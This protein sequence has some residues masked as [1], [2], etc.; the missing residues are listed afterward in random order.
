MHIELET[1]PN[2]VTNLRVE[3]PPDRVSLERQSIVKDFQGAARLPGYRVG[4]APKTL[5]ETRYKKEILD[6]LQRKLVSTATREAIAEKKLRVLS[7]GNVNQV[8]LG[9]DDTLRF[10][11]RVITAPEFELPPY[12]GLAVKVPPAEVA[13]ADVDRALDNL[14]QRLADFTD[15]EGRGLQMDD[16]SVIDFAAR[17]DGQ[18]VSEAIPDA[19]KELAG[20]EKFW[21]KLGP[22]TLLPGFSEALLGANAGDTR[23]FSLTVPADF[24]IESLQGKTL[25]YTVKVLELKQQALPELDDAFAEKVLPGK[26]LAQL[27]DLAREQLG[28][29]RAA[30]I[31]D[32]KRRQILHLLTAG[33]QF[34][35]PNEFVRGETQRIMGDIVKQNQER[36]VSDDEIRTN[37]KDIVTNADQAARERLKGAFIL[38]RIA[39]KEGIKVTREEM[40]GRLVSLAARSGMSREKLLKNLQEREALGQ[41]EEEILLGKTLAFLVANATVETVAPAAAEQAAEP[42]TQTAEPTL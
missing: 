39:E 2:C 21:V 41:V 19:P 7:I 24:P 38:T 30:M 28:T 40:D 16:F 20:K 35:L 1:L 26:T 18:P 10:T 36:G 15:I 25:E 31:E 14:R 23:D 27:R 5:V 12:Q 34:E 17:L 33:A 13:D 32:A 4:K 8:E 6:E 37:E 11:A 29:E 42:A 3:L 22:Q 9:K